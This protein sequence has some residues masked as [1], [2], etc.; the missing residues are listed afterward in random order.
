MPSFNK[1]RS[2]ILGTVQMGGFTNLSNRTRYNLRSSAMT[3]LLGA[4]FGVV[5]ST[6]VVALPEEPVDN[7]IIKNIMM[8]RV[9]IVADGQ[10][11]ELLTTAKT[12]EDL[13]TEQHIPLTEHDR[14][15]RPLNA[16]L[17]DGMTITI[18]RVRVEE[19]V[20][21]APIPFPVK[22]RYSADF[23]VGEKIVKQPGLPGEKTVV[24][25]D[26]Y[27]DGKRTERVCVDRKVTRP[28]PQVEI[29]GL[30]GLTLA[31]RHLLG[32]R[33]ILTMR[34]SAYGPSGNGRWGMRTASGMRP[35]YGVVAV[36]PRFIPL[37]T[38]LYIEGYGTAVAG[39]TGGAIKGDRIDLGMESD[40]EASQFG[41][42]R[43]RV[44]ILD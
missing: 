44:I 22:R 16:R 32:G 15:S 30:R 2:Q 21:R 20:E 41:R 31:S 11:S 9:T 12:V 8:R 24:F 36:D 17:K 13:L 34:A 4:V 35:G 3:L 14:C 38:R 18:T 37:G 7:K 28:Q 39:D 10:N 6:R 27:K 42:R 29:Q 25:R 23:E 40:G 33:R 26:Y 19:V 1:W 5:A 43:V